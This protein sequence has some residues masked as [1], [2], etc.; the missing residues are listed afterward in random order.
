MK[1]Q[2]SS[3]AGKIRP[4]RM[5]MFMRKAYGELS[6]DYEKLD[7][8]LQEECWPEASKLAHKLKSVVVLVDLNGLL[9]PLRTIE[10]IELAE[11]TLE[12]STVKACNNS[13]KVS[14]NDPPA[15][16]FAKILR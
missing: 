4:D 2:S 8:L 7:G 13:D 16:V 14:A 9:P 5:A 6:F 3:L 1:N 11:I 12:T 15:K 10:A